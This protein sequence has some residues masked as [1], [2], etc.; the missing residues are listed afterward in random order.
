MR[1]RKFIKLMGGAAVAWPLAA[2]AQQ[3]RM[4]V[5]GFL[6]T[7]ASG[8][9]PQLL[10]A[11]RSGLKEVGY[12]EGQNVVMEYRF[13]ENQYDRL[14]ALA[15]DLVRRQVAV[16]VANGPAAKAAKEA[17]PTIP[18]AFVAGFDPVEVGLVAS[19]SRPGGNITGV[20]ILDVEL[21]PKRLQLLHELAPTATIIAALVNPTDPARAETTS[22]ELQAAAHTLGLQLHVLHASTDRDFD[23]VFARLVELRAGGLVIGGEPFFNSRSEQLGAL[24]I[25][26]AMPTIY[27]LR[28]FAAAGGLV[29]YGGSLTDAY[30]L[31]GIYTGRILKGEKPADL[32]VQQSTKVEMVINLKTAKLFGLT[33]PQSL[34]GRADEVIE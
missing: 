19:M 30:H 15:A 27:Q 29:S 22:K 24:T 23:T 31:V 20:S 26:H 6:G 3:P 18:I 1:R 4:P 25:R 5:V 34:L 21:G 32:P 13:A 14:P 11:F 28:A 33:V 10:T 8:E 7:R 16:I 12:V 17:T 2:R 9:D